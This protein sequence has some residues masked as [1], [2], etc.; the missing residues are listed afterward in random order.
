[1]IT[2][3]QLSKW[4]AK[5][6]SG[7]AREKHLFG[8]LEPLASEDLAE[9]SSWNNVGDPDNEGLEG[10]QRPITSGAYE[11][12]PWSPS[13]SDRDGWARVLA[14]RPD[15]A[16]ALTKEVESEFR[17]VADGSTHRVDRLKA[18]GNGIVSPVVREFLRRI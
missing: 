4:I 16:P 9:S 6:E 8:F 7:P 17:R 3:K 1:M 10:W 12:A 13:P 14:E 18:L 11:R 2:A 5:W 15:L